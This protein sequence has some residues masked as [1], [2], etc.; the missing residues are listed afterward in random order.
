MLSAADTKRQ[1]DMA[2]TYT[3]PRRY[4]SQELLDALIAD[5]EIDVA[6]AERDS[7]HDYAEKVREDLRLLRVS[8]VPKHWQRYLD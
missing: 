7:L 6:C 4:T 1:F 2:E 3:S 8:H 5:L